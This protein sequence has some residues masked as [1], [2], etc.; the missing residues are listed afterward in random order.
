MI[1]YLSPLNEL[2]LLQGRRI[3]IQ[4]RTHIHTRTTFFLM[5]SQADAD[6]ARTRY[7]TYTYLLGDSVSLT[8]E[9]TSH[10][11]N[12]RNMRGA[13]EETTYTHTCAHFNSQ[14]QHTRSIRLRVC[15]TSLLLIHL[16]IYVSLNNVMSEFCVML[17]TYTHEHSTI[18][19]QVSR[20]HGFTLPCNAKRKRECISI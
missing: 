11:W 16:Y 18:A 20:L 1:S 17:K 12:D 5:R 6:A 2:Q 13:H 15:C 4:T 19:T 10:T 8:R 3:L 14:K 7:S 9:L